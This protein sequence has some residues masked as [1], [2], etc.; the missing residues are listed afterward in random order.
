LNLAGQT[1]L[2]E[3]VE[4]IRLS[5]LMICNDTGP[6]HIAAALGKPV[7]AMFGPTDPRR[8]GPYRQTQDVI[9][10][11]L[12]CVP[13]FSAACANARPL[14]C[15]FEI[16]PRAVFERIQRRHGRILSAAKAPDGEPGRS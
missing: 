9:Q 14:E 10:V 12:P 16:T 8:T 11:E 6:M 15:L 4:W 2:P 13:C 7:V 3:L 1:S 5:E